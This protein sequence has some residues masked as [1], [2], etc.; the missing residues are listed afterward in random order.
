MALIGYA[1]VSSEQKHLDDQLSRLQ[2][3]DK[4]FQERVS[5]NASV[6][7]QLQ[8]CLEY[9]SDGDTLVVT[10]LDRLSRSTSRLRQIMKELEDKNVELQVIDQHTK[11]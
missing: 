3:C 7:P 6:R 1:R 9:V 2:V 10:G 8:A 11:T 5:G 4:I